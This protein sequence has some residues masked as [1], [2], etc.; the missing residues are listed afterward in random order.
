MAGTGV[1]LY[2]EI[3]NALRRRVRK[4]PAGQPLPS[5]AEL[6]AQFGVSRMTARQAVKSLEA[7]GLLYRVPGAGTF[8]TGHEAHRA[9]G[10]LR[11]FSSEMAEKG[12]KVR[13][14]VLHAGWIHPDAIT[15]ANLGLA[16]GNRAILVTRV[17]YAND[18]P[19]AIE[20]ATLTPRCS[21]VLEHDLSNT[22]LHALLEQHD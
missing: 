7:D 4:T 3:A 10:Q 8:A 15:Q 20:N 17:R 14:K 5:E 9:M 22:S 18:T 1:P 6:A 12:F 11:S 2:V 21:F 16:P 19:T 13:S